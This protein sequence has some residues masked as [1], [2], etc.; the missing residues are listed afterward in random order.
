MHDPFGRSAMPAGFSREDRVALLGEAFGAWFRGSQPSDEARLFVA[1]AALAWLGGGRGAGDLL[2]DFWK[3]RGRQG[4]TATPPVLW[5]ALR[6]EGRD[7]PEDS[8]CGHCN[9]NG[10]AP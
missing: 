6:E 5:T 10:P 1:G 4:S 2:A 3:V 8:E 9:F 7:A